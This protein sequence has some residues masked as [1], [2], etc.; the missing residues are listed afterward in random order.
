MI[1]LLFVFLMAIIFYHL[2]VDEDRPEFL[3]GEFDEETID[4]ELCSG[5]G[6][7]VRY[8]GRSEDFGKMWQVCVGDLCSRGR[9]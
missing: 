2:W 1:K 8:Y 7:G 4:D 9:L 6:G 3:E 5:V